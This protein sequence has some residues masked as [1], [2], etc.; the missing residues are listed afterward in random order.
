MVCPTTHPL[1][2]LAA[3][4]ETSN[5]LSTP[6]AALLTPSSTTVNVFLK[7]KAHLNTS[8][9]AVFSHEASLASTVL[10]AEERLSIALRFGNAS[11]QAYP[12][13]AALVKASAVLTPSLRCPPLLLLVDADLHESI[14]SLCTLQGFCGQCSGGHQKLCLLLNSAD[15]C[16]STGMLTCAI[17]NVKLL[18]SG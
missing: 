6:V 15:V 11:S 9:R 13:P 16:L 4:P 18:S 3:L 7:L 17:A 10:G 1:A 14:L 8:V 2:A 5:R 12:R